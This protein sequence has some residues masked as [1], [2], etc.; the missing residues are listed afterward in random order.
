[1]SYFFDLV[2]TFHCLLCTEDTPDDVHLSLAA[3]LM[4]SAWSWSPT[5]IG[6]NTIA[7]ALIG[8]PLLLRLGS[9]RSRSTARN[10]PLCPPNLLIS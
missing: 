4:T 6:F 1:M 8:V 10:R 9:A 5:W 7:C 2:T 3:W